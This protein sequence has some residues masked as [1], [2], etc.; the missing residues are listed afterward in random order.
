MM[1]LTRLCLLYVCPWLSAPYYAIR[2]SFDP[3]LLRLITIT[4]PDDIL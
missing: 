4:F 1:P 3:P 2:S